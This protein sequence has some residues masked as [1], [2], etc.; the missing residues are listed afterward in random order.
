MLEIISK[1]KIVE[2][3][4]NN[5]LLHTK[6]LNFKLDIVISNITKEEI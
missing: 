4:H 3:F 6:L 1:A 2:V 5:K